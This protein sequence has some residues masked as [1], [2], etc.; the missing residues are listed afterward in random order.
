M[1]GIGAEE[2]IAVLIIA[3]IVLGPDRLPVLM[4]TLG[5]WVRRLRA[6]SREFREEFAEEFQFLQEELDVLRR[7]ADETRAELADIRRELTDTAEETA[8]ELRGARD[9][10]MGEVE[11]VVSTDGPD[12][13]Q[14]PRGGDGSNARA[15]TTV[16]AAKAPSAAAASSDRPG[17]A[18]VM[19]QAIVETFNP[20]GSEESRP[21]EPAVASRAAATAV[22][23]QSAAPD[24]HVEEPL[25]EEPVRAPTAA[26]AEVYRA[27]AATLGPSGVVSAAEPAWQNQLGG[28]M[29]LMIMKAVEE[30]P[31]FRKQAEDTLRAQARV[32]AQ[33]LTEIEDADP[34]EIAEAWARQ[35][36]QLVSPGSVTVEQKAPQ[37]AVIELL[38]CPYG[39]KQGDAHPVCD[40]SNVYDAEFFKRFGAEGVYGQRMSDGAPHC[41]LLVVEK[42]RLRQFGV[43]LTDDEEDAEADSSADAA[44][45]P[46]SDPA[47]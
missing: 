32:D 47:G 43:V 20:N 13:P 36:R 3:L 19:A 9:E 46:I 31:E 35:R 12:S 39:L 16:P 11:S 15:D 6:M 44:E 34:R 8:A 27:P 18:D 4:R 24:S 45:Q 10:I 7:E 33:R 2:L 5:R 40:V 42:E 22:P 28:F 23:E 29:R 37:S 38:E 21:A 1:F 26:T 41:Q 17:P 14:R 25:A 30:E